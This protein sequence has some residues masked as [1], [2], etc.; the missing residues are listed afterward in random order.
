VINLFR[1]SEISLRRLK[2]ERQKLPGK[3]LQLLIPVHPAVTT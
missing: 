3:T 1:D 2:M